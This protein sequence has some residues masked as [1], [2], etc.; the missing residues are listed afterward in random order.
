MAVWAT[1]GIH[2]A[3]DKVVTT[4]E[5]EPDWVVIEWVVGPISGAAVNA[6]H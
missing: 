5:L 6:S 4:T 3:G 1:Q 2:I